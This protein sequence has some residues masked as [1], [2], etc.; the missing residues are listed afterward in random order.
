KTV[1]KISIAVN[2]YFSS[3][4]AGE[5]PAEGTAAG[6]GE[7]EA[8]ATPA[9]EVLAEPG[10]AE[11]EIAADEA[12]EAERATSPTEGEE[13]GAE[14]EGE[15]PPA[16]GE[17]PDSAGQSGDTQGLSQTASAGNESV[18]ELVEEGQ[19][20]EAALQSGVE[21]APDADVS[22]VHVHERPSK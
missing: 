19:P 17:G 22:E 3:L 8:A 11:A 13:P 4:E 12:A 5:A 21:N 7:P 15:I 16:D 20:D 6:E 10:T 18:S 2:N 9:G 1:E 14:V